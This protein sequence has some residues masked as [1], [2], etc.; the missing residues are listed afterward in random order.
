MTEIDDRYNVCRNLQVSN[1]DEAGQKKRGRASEE[2]AKIA[3]E[4]NTIESACAKY[5]TIKDV[6]VYLRISRTT[7]WRY[8]KM[9]ILR[10]RKIGNKTLYARADIDNYIDGKEADNGNN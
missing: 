3:A 8:T 2:I 9:G 6:C 7:V 5:L 10:P 4:V 1:E